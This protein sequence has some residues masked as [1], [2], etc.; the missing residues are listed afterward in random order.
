M[1][2][3]YIFVEREDTLS[4]NFEYFN[5]ENE[6]SAKTKEQSE[7]FIIKGAW[8]AAMKKVTGLFRTILLKSLLNIGSV[9]FLSLILEAITDW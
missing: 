9:D 1:F 7:C 2:Q 6:I 5:F 3:S 4:T 8:G